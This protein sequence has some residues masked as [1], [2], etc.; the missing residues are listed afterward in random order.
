MPLVNSRALWVGVLCC[1]RRVCRVRRTERCQGGVIW[2][3]LLLYPQYGQSD[4]IQAFRDAD[5]LA[6]HL[7]AAFPEEGP[8][9]PWDT[10]FEYRSGRAVPSLY[11]LRCL[12]FLL[13]SFRVCCAGVCVGGLGAGRIMLCMQYHP[14]L[15]LSFF[16]W[17]WCS[18]WGAGRMMP[19]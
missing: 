5:M 18:C 4:L 17:Y 6:E 14:P 12:V 19:M 8:P 1:R 9:A 11:G 10:S 7:A 16:A 2:P 15:G 13:V 3:V